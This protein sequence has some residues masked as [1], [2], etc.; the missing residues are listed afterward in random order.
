MI[1]IAM[2]RALEITRS[3]PLRFGRPV[4]PKCE[5]CGK[6]KTDCTCSAP[7]DPPPAVAA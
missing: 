1:G 6:S 5:K 3:N 2:I 4:D 7:Q